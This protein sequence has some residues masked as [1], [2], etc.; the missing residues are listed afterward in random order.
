[1]ETV[2]MDESARVGEAGEDVGDEGVCRR[3]IG[4]SS[5]VTFVWLETALSTLAVWLDVSDV[6]PSRC[7]CRALSLSLT[8]FSLSFSLSLSLSFDLS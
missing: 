5:S 4:I 8:F 6:A 2:D 1:M 3:L 7:F